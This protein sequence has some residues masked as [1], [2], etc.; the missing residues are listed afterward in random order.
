MGQ[1]VHPTS[2]RIPTIYTWKSQWYADKQYRDLLAEDREIRDAIRRTLGRDAG[3]SRVEIERNAN[4]AD[5]HDCE[6]GPQAPG[7]P[8]GR[9]F[10]SGRAGRRNSSLRADQD[11]SSERWRG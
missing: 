4:Q 8:L 3:I 5:D 9:G 10:G 7:R 2:F 6:Q 1:K 11:A